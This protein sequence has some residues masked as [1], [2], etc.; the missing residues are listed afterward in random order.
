M[1]QVA[2][3]A[4]LLRDSI[5]TIALGLINRERPK[6][7]VAE[8][9]SYNRFTRVAEVLLSGESEANSTIQARFPK[10]IQPS[11][12][13]MDDGIGNATGDL[14]LVEGT[15]NN[16]RITQVVEGNGTAFGLILGDTTLLGGTLLD[17]KVARHFSKEVDLPGAGESVH[18]GRF[19]FIHDLD[20]ANQAWS[21]YGEIV[22]ESR[23]YFGGSKT[24]KLAID[25]SAVTATWQNVF[26]DKDSGVRNG[27]DFA[28]EI[29]VADD[30]SFELR[31]RNVRSNTI[32]PPVG[33]V[34]SMWLHGQDYEYDTTNYN[35]FDAGVS[36]GVPFRTEDTNANE[37]VDGWNVQ[38]GPYFMPSKRIVHGRTFENLT[39]GG[40]I[41]WDDR[42]VK[43]TNNLTSSIG[44][45]NLITNGV[46]QI[47][48]PTV[49]QSIY[50]HG[51][52]G[53]TL[54]IA[55]TSS[56]VDM[57]PVS[58]THSVLYYAPDYGSADGAGG[59]YHVVGNDLNFSVPSHWI[60]LAVMNQSWDYLK[61]ATGHTL[62]AGQTIVGGVFAQPYWYGYISSSPTAVAGAAVTTITTWVADGSPNSYGITHSSGIFTVPFL[63]R[64]NFSAQ[65]WWSGVSGATGNRL[66][67]LMK[68]SPNNIIQSSTV[69]S[70]AI[71]GAGS[72]PALNQLSKSVV[73][74][75]GEQVYVR[76]VHSDTVNRAPTGAGP[77]ISF[78][79]I[80]YDG[81][82]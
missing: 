63:A 13:K 42:Y 41:T 49:G 73:L 44:R 78:V 65:L 8:V 64:W 79:Q 40:T 18:L 60:M 22:V 28:L 61:L 59:R 75:A 27:N 51:F 38:Q 43:W 67:Q 36:P 45:S 29:F 2:K 50:Y 72:V 39:G 77:D 66:A 3:G 80:K 57:M 54:T 10:H 71:I 17:R 4:L 47:A 76:F 32:A 34:F 69:N 12:A 82:A 7:R 9:Y 53:G 81:Q 24:Y 26:P 14:V 37:T 33:Y 68:V 25:N 16:Y 30:H 20:Y 58:A 55:Y 19:Y 5:T 15:V 31:V 74:A 56:G 6:P 35:K 1:V 62:K 21:A 70:S 52:T 46:V 48:P 23:V 11:K